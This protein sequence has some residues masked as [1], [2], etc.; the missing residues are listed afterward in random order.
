[1]RLGTVLKLACVGACA[2]I[3]A[4]IAV[5]K[6]IDV[7]TYRGVLVQAAK[8]ATGRD[9]SIRGKLSLKLSLTP[10]LI[11]EDITLS[12]APWGERPEMARL[13]RL[14]ADIGLLPLLLR[15][16][17]LNRLQLSGLDVVLERNGAGQ[18]NW[19]FGSSA[20]I[21]RSAAAVDGAGTPTTFKIGQVSIDHAQIVYRDALGGRTE[22]VTI[23]QLRA[24]ADTLSAPL[25]RP[26]RGGGDGQHVEASG[27][28]GPIGSLGVP[29]K[30]YPIKLK[31]VLPGLVATANG[32]VTTDREK[33]PVL[34]LQVTADATE[35][36]EAAKFAGY[37][38]PPLGAARIAL[39]V[40]GPLSAPG[41][42]NIDAVL[43]RRDLVAVTAK[44]TVKAPLTAEGV[45]LVMFAEGENIAGLNRG[46]DLGLP[47]IG[48]VK[49][50]AH[51]TDIEGGWRLGELK[52]VLGRSDIAGDISLRLRAGR[53]SMEA[54]LVSQQIDLGELGGARS[55]PAKAR[56]E[57][58]RLFPDDPL[59]LTLVGLADADLSWRIDRLL[60]DGLTAQQVDL[61]LSDKG[62]KLTVTPK[63]QSLAGG[64]AS[65]AL[66]V[67]ATGKTAHVTL[68]L[69][70]EK[71]MAGDLLRGLGLSQGVKGG[72]TSLHAAVRGNGNSVRSV[73]ARLNGDVTVVTD[74]ATLD[75]AYADMIALDVLRQ[76]SPWTQQKNTEMQCLVSRFTVA[77]GMA[78]SEALLFDTDV[79]TV[80]GQGSI[81]LANE[82]LDLTVAPRPKDA[83][84]ISLALPLDV[85][86]TLT[87]PTVTPNRGA[88]VKGVASVAAGLALGPV[89]AI[90]PLM[91]AGADDSNPC[92]AAINQAKKPAPPATKKPA[93][94]GV[95]ND[96]GRAA[97]G[98]LGD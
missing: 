25:G 5:V 24:A 78:H 6:S 69:D 95:L 46:L 12:N 20:S 84:L 57:Q 62:G 98:L 67:D 81:N 76:L 64:K 86:G 52:L 9:L 49:G 85:G 70:A 23:E 60:G 74:K 65:G 61:V 77:D 82:V 27:V 48:P 16:V 72:R 28:L 47:S 50:S 33:G 34:A 93:G 53:P 90:L 29:G 71:V 38:I 22:T 44:G 40:T 43:G 15:E 51:L 45:D 7:N 1:M 94:K 80:S 91:S 56:N 21:A 32:T 54:R 59:P 96:I 2:L 92:L 19:T 39:G 75:N 10:A 31:A 63:V 37:A 79:M 58:N 89:G 36:A 13:Q 11:A 87:H 18:T 8:A 41:L 55:E 68:N 73:L 3:V 4:L 88:I 42:V 14:R 17:R 26:G 97:R 30:P 66:S 35:V 83:S